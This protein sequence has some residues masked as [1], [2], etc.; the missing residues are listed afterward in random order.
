MLLKYIIPMTWYDLRSTMSLLFYGNVVSGVLSEYS[1]LSF[2][3]A[4]PD[5]V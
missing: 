3:A 5:T 1:A 4:R 2:S